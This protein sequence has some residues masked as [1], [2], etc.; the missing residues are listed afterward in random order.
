MHLRVCQVAP[1]A[2]VT[3]ADGELPP[4][5]LMEHT[6][7][8][9]LITLGVCNLEPRPDVDVCEGVV[10]G[11][12]PVHPQAAGDVQVAPRQELSSPEIMDTNGESCYLLHTV[13]Q[14]SFLYATFL[15]SCF[16]ALSIIKV[17]AIV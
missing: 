15:F 9:L 4:E 14:S 12:P 8:I 6:L 7:L 3:P 2:L 1:H 13:I 10:L 11:P 17:E 5:H 16:H